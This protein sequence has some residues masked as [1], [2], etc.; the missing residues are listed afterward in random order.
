MVS[1]AIV[2]ATGYGGVELIRL[3]QA[4]PQVRLAYLSSES[5][6]GQRLAEV[7]P[8]LAGVEAVL[9]PLDP[10]AVAAECQAAMLALPA[11]KSM[12][13]APALL[14]AGVR[15]VDVSADFRLRDPEIYRQ[16]YKLDHTCPELLAEAV[17]GIPEWY[18]D[19]IASARLV[20]APGCYATAAVLALAPLLAEKLIA[21]EDIVVDGKSG[22][23]GAGR[24]SLS[25]PYHYPEANEDLSAYAVGGH[26][27]LP[28][29]VQGL[30]ELGEAVPSVTFTPHLVPM[31]RGILLTIY[32]RPQEGADAEALR[33][34]LQRYYAEE[35]FV[36]V[37]PAGVW[38]H[39]KWTAGT[40][41]CFV[42]VGMDKH[43]GRAVV[44]SALDNL[45][46]GM[47]G[48]MVQCLNLMIGAEESTCLATPAAYP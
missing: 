26:R 25:L 42:A 3:L 39:T 43:S 17:P 4:H 19:E 21:P 35:R 46:K 16:W 5:Y 6:A 20:A 29:M 8:H 13:V 15:I 23:S 34:S 40:N 45:G 36:Q 7:Y 48:Q 2:G 37:L 33:Q 27:H 47:S 22:V 31:A 18:R 12:E 28:E 1:V 38:P 11:G 44:L 41:L 32:V 9:R 24:T 30:Q 14:Q 10:A